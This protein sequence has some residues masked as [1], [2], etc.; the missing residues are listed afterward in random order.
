ML[1]NGFSSVESVLSDDINFHIYVNDYSK[2][3]DK[4][5]ISTGFNSKGN[6]YSDN[7]NDNDS[8]DS[9]SDNNDK[10]LIMTTVVSFATASTLRIT[11]IK[12]LRQ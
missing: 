7:C 3:G 11:M 5:S 1:L 12:K 8:E 4:G 6:C 10:I 9:D 2:R